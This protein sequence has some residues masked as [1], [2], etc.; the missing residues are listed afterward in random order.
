MNGAQ[1]GGMGGQNRGGG[2]P[3]GGGMGGGQGGGGRNQGAGGNNANSGRGN[4]Q[5]LRFPTKLGFRPTTTAIAV[6][7]TQLEMR[8]AKVPALTARNVAVRMDGRVAI[9]EGVVGSEHEKNLLRQLAKL[10][11]GISE[12]NVDGLLVDSTDSEA[13]ALPPPLSD[14]K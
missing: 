7:A 3:L 10:E 4:Q 14:D 11:P 13:E 12:A 6:R 9:L 1:G 8:L 2:V 5:P